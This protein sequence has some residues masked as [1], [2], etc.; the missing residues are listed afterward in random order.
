MSPILIGVIILAVLVILTMAVKIL[1]EHERAVIFRL[2]GLAGVK[3]P[4]FFLIIPVIDKMIKVDLWLTP[5]DDF[6]Y[7]LRGMVYAAQGRQAEA[8]ADFEKYLLSMGQQDEVAKEALKRMIE[9]LR[10]Q[11]YIKRLGPPKNT[12][13]ERGH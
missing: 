13:L 12:S 3:G 2:G 5:T 10:T 4:G 1:S 9:E 11:G 6:G 8:I 7:Y